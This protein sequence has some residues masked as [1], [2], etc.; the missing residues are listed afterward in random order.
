MD[1]RGMEVSGKGMF[2]TLHE[3]EV[4]HEKQA[5][6]PGKGHC[7]SAAGPLPPPPLPSQAGG[8]V[9]HADL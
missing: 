6:S 7:G 4:S 1:E 5:P 8:F 3:N 2:V 9:R